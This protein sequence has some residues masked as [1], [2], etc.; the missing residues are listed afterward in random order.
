LDG[1]INWAYSVVVGGVGGALGANEVVN[2]IDVRDRYSS[3]S[4][5]GLQ[6][7][8]E[9]GIAALIDHHREL[10]MLV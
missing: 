5:V 4:E 6:V 2:K 3:S 1:K 7:S 8:M 10:G 9:R